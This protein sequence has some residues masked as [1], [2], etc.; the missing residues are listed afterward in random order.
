[1]PAVDIS[2]GYGIS[3]KYH[4]KE[5]RYIVSSQARDHK[6]CNVH[7]ACVLSPSS[8]QLRFGFR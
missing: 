1:M 8:E 5:F 6:G 2:G 4:G 7:E 3:I